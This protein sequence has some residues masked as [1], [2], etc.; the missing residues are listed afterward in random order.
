[1]TARRIV[2]R[3]PRRSTR[4]W[5]LAALVVIG[6]CAYVVLQLAGLRTSLDSE[7]SNQAA[8]ATAIS[9]LASALD[10]SRTQLKDHGVT[11]SASS[12]G[13]ILRGTP[14]AQGVQGAQGAQGVPGRDAPTPD[15]TE[16]AGLAAS[17]VT[18]SPGPS[19]PP[20]ES[21]TGPP[22][23]AGQPGADSTVPGP[24]GPAGPS[25]APGQ[26]GAPGPEGPPG[27]AGAA[28]PPPSSWT[29]TDPS[30]TSYECVEDEPGGTTYSCSQ[31]GS[32]P[33]SPSPTPDPSQSTATNSSVRAEGR[34]PVIASTGPE[35]P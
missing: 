10:T 7:R 17:M 25:G 8:Q 16:I 11:P 14:G 29:W 2:A 27:P 34:Q 4:W 13:Q 24:S 35:W 6:G 32:A 31:T 9:K 12:A 21:I 19:G 28:G 18:P 30:G 1:M 20:G 3:S 22:G 33:A 23:A 15:V 26:D 5:A